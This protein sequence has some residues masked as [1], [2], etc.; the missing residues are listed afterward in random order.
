MY[1]INKIPKQGV[2]IKK[3]RMSEAIETASSGIIP[4]FFDENQICNVDPIKEVYRSKY[5]AGLSVSYV[6]LLVWRI[7]NL[8]KL[9][10]ENFISLISRS[11]GTVLTSN[12]KATILST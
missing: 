10:D 6:Y 5:N 11:D 2:F 4:V 7:N 8:I 12:E 3:N 1:R 9:I